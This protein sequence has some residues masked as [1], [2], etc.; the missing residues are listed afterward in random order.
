MTNQKTEFR[1]YR[2]LNGLDTRIG[3]IW[4]LSDR[5]FLILGY[6][7][8]YP[9]VRARVMN[10]DLFEIEFFVFEID[11]SYYRLIARLDDTAD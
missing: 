2:F 6:E 4:T 9:Q 1:S 8:L 10:L 7:E 5:L 3:D 11:S